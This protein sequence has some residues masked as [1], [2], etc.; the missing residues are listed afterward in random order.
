MRS[1]VFLLLTLCLPYCANAATLRVVT[2][3]LPPLQI[4]DNN[5]VGG[6]STE[7]VRALLAQAGDT[8]EIEATN[9]ARSYKIAL[10][11][12]NVMIYSLSRGKSREKLFKW[13]GAILTLDNYLWRL[14]K[15]TDINVTTLAHA[16]HYRTVVTR[17]DVQH[18]YL[19][20]QGFSDPKDLTVVSRYEDAIEMMLRARVDIYAGTRLFLQK[21]LNSINKDIAD[22]HPMFK[23]DPS[24][25]TLYIAFSHKTSDAMVQ[26]YRKALATIKQNG[27]Y[28][29]LLKKWQNQLNVTQTPPNISH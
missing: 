26:K 3:H 11:K 16:K 14:K 2:E 17:Q 10:T 28:D 6:L 5:R 8:A 1:F 21:R 12:E 20:S 25:G 13:V 19:Q 24:I 29:T 23:M 27:S 15:R 4:V 22:W 7:I 18:L 9:W